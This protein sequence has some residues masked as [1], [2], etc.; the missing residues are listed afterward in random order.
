MKKKPKHRSTPL[1]GQWHA[2][3][4]STVATARPATR[5][6][7][8]PPGPTPR[9]RRTSPGRSAATAAAVT[10]EQKMGASSPAAAAHASPSPA[11]WSPCAC[12]RKWAAIVT[13]DGGGVH[14]SI[15]TA[16]ADVMG[17][18]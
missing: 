14:A 8:R 17:M 16:C 1:T 3:T 6:T 9:R 13:G 4:A 10:G 5:T 2:S 12:D 7:T 15:A 11:M 18:M